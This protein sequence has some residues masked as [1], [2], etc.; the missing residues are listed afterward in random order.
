M[1]IQERGDSKLTFIIDTPGQ[2]FG[3]SFNSFQLCN[4][5]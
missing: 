1:Y 5:K 2:S 3:S 4:F